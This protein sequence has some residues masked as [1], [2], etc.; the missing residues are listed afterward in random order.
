MIIQSK[1]IVIFRNL[2]FVNSLSRTKIYRIFN[3]FSNNQT[4]V[5]FVQFSYFGLIS[6][7]SHR[8]ESCRYQFASYI[9]SLAISSFPNPLT[10]PSSPPSLHRMQLLINFLVDSPDFSLFSHLDFIA[11]WLVQMRAFKGP[12]IATNLRQLFLK[13]LFKKDVFRKE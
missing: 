3:L 9:H 6:S 7:L 5:R 8:I 13:L 1:L 2:R 12:I 10:S 4:I 11:H